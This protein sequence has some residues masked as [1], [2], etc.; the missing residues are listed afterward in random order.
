MSC[1]SQLNYK[2]LRHKYID[3]VL[4]VYKLIFVP[5]RILEWVR[6]IQEILML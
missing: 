6:V 3:L 4:Q 1:T 2:V 5:V